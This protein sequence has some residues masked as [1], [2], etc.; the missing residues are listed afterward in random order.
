LENGDFEYRVKIQNM[1]TRRA[2]L[3][4]MIY[5]SIRFPGISPYG[6]PT[7]GTVPTVAMILSSQ[8]AIRV[9][10]N[11]AKFVYIRFSDTLATEQA[12]R[13]IGHLYPIPAQRANLTLEDLLRR[14]AGA[15]LA[16]DILCFDEWSGARKYFSSHNYGE[17]DVVLGVFRGLDVVADAHSPPTEYGTST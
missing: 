7:A 13:M 9:P 4:V 8:H 6:R 11:L 2:A 15:Y 17:K 14:S 3:D 12:V 10:P 16:F 1:S 5:G